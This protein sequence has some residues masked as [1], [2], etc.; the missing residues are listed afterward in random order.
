M[1][2]PLSFL[3]FRDPGSER[4]KKKSEATL[5]LG[6]RNP[7]ILILSLFTF[8]SCCHLHKKTTAVKGI[9]FFQAWR[10][11]VPPVLKKGD[12]EKE[13]GVKGPFFVFPN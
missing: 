5:A 4:G 3:L 8:S 13:W 9:P 1:L 2:V 11:E 6:T 7:S 10:R 12:Q